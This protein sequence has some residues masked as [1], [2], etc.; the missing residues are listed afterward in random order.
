MVDM[1][2]Y[3]QRQDMLGYFEQEFAARV[4]D[5]NT[6]IQDFGKQRKAEKFNYLLSLFALICFAAPAY[7]EAKGSFQCGLV[8]MMALFFARYLTDTYFEAL[9]RLADQEFEFRTLKSEVE[10]IQ[11]TI[12]EQL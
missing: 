5:I 4:K 2:S 6:T 7:L 1:T 11:A 12:A 10:G 3:Q 9:R 8:G